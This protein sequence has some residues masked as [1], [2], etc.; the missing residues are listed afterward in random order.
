MFL[1][2]QVVSGFS[3][4][5]IFKNRRFVYNQGSRPPVDPS[6]AGCSIRPKR[7]QNQFF[8][9]C[10]VDP[11]LPMILAWR[12]VPGFSPLQFAKHPRFVSLQRGFP[13]TYGYPLTQYV[14]FY[15]RRTIG[16]ID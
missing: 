7:P 15:Q 14:S 12:V 5:Q 2:L 4:L 11:N 8:E 6:L 3:P 16:Q 9:N 1:A 10:L 13:A